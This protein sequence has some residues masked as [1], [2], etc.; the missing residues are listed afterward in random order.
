MH[1]SDVTTII[2]SGEKEKYGT[3]RNNNMKTDSQI[4]IG[5]TDTDTDSFFLLNA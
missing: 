2:I 1:K 3:R 4:W 5:E